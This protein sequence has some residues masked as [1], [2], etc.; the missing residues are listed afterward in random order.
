L[1]MLIVCRHS[2]SRLGL[3]KFQGQFA[4]TYLLFKH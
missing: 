1:L 3:S 4:V 2:S